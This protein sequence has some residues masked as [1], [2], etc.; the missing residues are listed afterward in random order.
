MIKVLVLFI[1]FVILGCFVGKKVENF[2]GITG[3]SRYGKKCKGCNNSVCN[4]SDTNRCIS[5]ECGS[6]NSVT[7]ACGH[8]FS[9]PEDMGKCKVYKY[10]H[11]YGYGTNNGFHY[12][13]PYYMR[14]VKY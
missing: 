13:E 4:C 1:L 2:C 7:Q 10:P 12:G 5:N 9:S 11:Y 6:N 8:E 14:K 3:V